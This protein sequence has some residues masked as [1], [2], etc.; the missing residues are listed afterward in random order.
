M[1]GRAYIC[2]SKGNKMWI[3]KISRKLKK[4]AKINVFTS[5]LY[6]GEENT[7]PAKGLARTKPKPSAAIVV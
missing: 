4:E 3:R 6:Q 2:G 1:Y 7:F 5:F